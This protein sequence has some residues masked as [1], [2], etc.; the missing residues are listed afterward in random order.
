MNKRMMATMAFLV[1]LFLSGCAGSPPPIRLN[2][3][4]TE[5][6]G[7][8]GAYCWDGGLLS[9]TVCVDPV[10]PVFDASIPL[11]AGTPIQLNIQK[12]FPDTVTL[13]LSKEAFGETI[14]TETVPVFSFIRWVTEVNAGEYVLT[15][16]ATW[17]KK[18]DSSY[19]FKIKLDQ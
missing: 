14:V 2:V 13:S 19:W 11:Q 16:H 6:D 12:P 8:Q 4:G 15:V 3:N 10:E 7:I 5:M 18:G 17:A 9:G 1:M